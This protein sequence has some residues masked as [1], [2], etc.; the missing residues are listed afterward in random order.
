V[1]RSN[2][3]V[4]VCGYSDKGRTDD[5]LDR[6]LDPAVE[7]AA[8]AI[9][10][11]LEELGLGPV[12]FRLLLAEVRK[13]IQEHIRW[14]L[15]GIIDTLCATAK[16]IT[17]AAVLAELRRLL[18]LKNVVDGFLERFHRPGEGIDI[19]VGKLAAETGVGLAIIGALAELAELVF[20]F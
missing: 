12:N 20:A 4:L 14:Y 5:F 6:L 17:L 2:R 1:T 16:V 13:R 10:R 15:Q 7:L 9:R 3:D 11:R 18:R 8:R 19:P